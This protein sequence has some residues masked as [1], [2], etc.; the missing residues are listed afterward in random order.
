MSPIGR[1]LIVVNLLLA[2][3][4]LG[5]AATT[6]KAG[7]N[8]KAQFE[9]LEAS[10]AAERAEL[11]NQ[12][13][14]NTTQLTQANQGRAEALQ[15]ADQNKVLA[16][17][18]QGRL[19]DAARDNDELRSQLAGMNERLEL[20]ASNVDT[21]TERAQASEREA[22]EAVLA[23]E[24]AEDAQAVAELAQKDAEDEARRLSTQVAQLTSEVE[25]LSNSLGRAERDLQAVAK[26]TGVNLNAII[27]P[28]VLNKAVVDARL[29]LAPGF[30]AIDAGTEDGVSVGMTFHIYRGATYKGDVRVETVSQGM[31]SAVV[32]VAVP[33]TSIGIGDSATTAL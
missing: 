16:D 1:I 8:W 6:V 3:A 19:D 12:L 22:R 26:L 33:G 11:Q 29:D 10:S 21:V 24:E 25:G 18:L 23:K 31:C 17:T 15:R 20:L 28:P 27:S 5:W 14:A 7:Q 4:F 2:G 9:G 30:V 32:T 13:S